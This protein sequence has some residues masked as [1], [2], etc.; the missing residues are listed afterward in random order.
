MKLIKEL[1]NKYR[2]NNK[3]LIIKISL[4]IKSLNILSRSF[5]ETIK[6]NITVTDIIKSGNK[7]PKIVNAGIKKNKSKSK[8]AT[9][10]FKLLLFDL[11]KI[12]PPYRKFFIFF[13]F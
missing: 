1:V 10:N 9:L 13:Y 4:I 2:K 8:W 5:N 6:E 12:N 11:I 3:K 7:G